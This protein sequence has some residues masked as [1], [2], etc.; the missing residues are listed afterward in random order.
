M[1]GE[2]WKAS[3]DFVIVGGGQGL[4][5]AGTGAP[6]RVNTS[7][8]RSGGVCS[9]QRAKRMKASSSTQAVQAL[10]PPTTKQKLLA[11]LIAFSRDYPLTRDTTGVHQGYPESSKASAS[12]SHSSSHHGVGVRFAIAV[13]Q[14]GPGGVRIQQPSQDDSRPLHQVGSSRRA[15]GVGGVVGVAFCGQ[16]A[17]SRKLLT[18]SPLR[19]ESR[20][21]AQV[22]KSWHRSSVQDSSEQLLVNRI[23][24]YVGGRIGYYPSV[25][26]TDNAANHREPQGMR[27]TL[28][29]GIIQKSGYPSVIP[30]VHLD[31][32]QRGTNTDLELASAA[33]KPQRFSE[34]APLFRVPHLREHII[35][36]TDAGVFSPPASITCGPEGPHSTHNASHT[37]PTTPRLYGRTCVLGVVTDK[38]GVMFEQQ[39]Q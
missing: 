5:F 37:W 23:I 33:R 30:A 13:V 14:H 17:F 12:G 16:V 20:V 35:R 28:S 31:Q 1:V 36:I 11:G 29:P 26:A 7:K 6:P 25:T 18:L 9:R 39:C 8:R 24:Q 19:G 38:V 10:R 21:G 2:I 32:T 27:W 22:W 3:S 34:R 15:G 4:F